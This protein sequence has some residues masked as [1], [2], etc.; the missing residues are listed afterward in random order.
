MT[1]RRP[2][3]ALLFASALAACGET[4][5]PPLAC[6]GAEA[7]CDR[8]YDEVAYATAHNAMSNEEDGWAAPNQRFPIPRQ[9]QDGIRGLM[10]DTYFFEGETRLC[11][12]S[13]VFGS[14]PLAEGLGEIR[15]FLQAH[16]HEVLTLIFEPYITP[17]QTEEAMR[18]SGLLPLLHAQTPGEPWP[19]LREMIASGRRVVALTQEDGGARPWYLDLWA[20]SWDTPYAAKTPDEL[21]C[22][23]GRG[24]EGADLFN[25]NHFLTAPFASPEL[26][27]RVN[28]N[29]F[30]LERVRDC[31]AQNG[32]RL[33]NF[34]S[35]DFYDQGDVLDVVRVL[36]GL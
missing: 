34:V 17:E 35:V 11:H 20:L 29:P 7:L 31:M 24:T 32:G 19:T 22:T 2:L 25:V 4:P 12:G 15:A 10:L 23:E 28:H 26:A 9:L 36:N 1:T 30:L 8:R 27:D 16:P 6:N 5:P 33:A 14:K 21:R 13:C 18:E 3:P